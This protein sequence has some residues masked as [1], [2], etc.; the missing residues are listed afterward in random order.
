VIRLGQAWTTLR[1]RRLK[2]GSARIADPASSA[3]SAEDLAPGELLGPIVGTG[4]GLLELLEVQ[5]E[6]KGRQSAADWARGARLAPGE[7][8]GEDPA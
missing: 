1:G 7:R 6:G 4:S 3:S 5:P 2:I 8:L